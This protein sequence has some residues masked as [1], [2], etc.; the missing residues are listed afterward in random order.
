MKIIDLIQGSDQWHLF[1]KGHIGASDASSVMGLNPFKSSLQ[2]WEEKVFGWENEMT[3]K[4]RLGQEMEQEAREAYETM[5][6]L[7]VFPIVLEHDFHDFI[8]ASMDGMNEDRSFAVEIKCGKG[9]HA[10]ASM[11]RI[12]PYYMCQ[13]QHQ[14]FVS[15]LNEIDYFSY[16]K[17]DTFL[18]NVKRDNEFIEKLIA[19]ELSFWNNILQFIPP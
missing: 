5:T 8:S 15:E 16:S 18:I 7:K 14:M 1:R 3:D 10:L 11:N 4:M 13:L 17:K 19:K 2:L 12:P 6:G 9:S